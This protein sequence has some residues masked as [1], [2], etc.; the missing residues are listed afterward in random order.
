VIFVVVGRS[1]PWA[2]VLLQP[3]VAVPAMVNKQ[4]CQTVSSSVALPCAYTK[5]GADDVLNIV[6]STVSIPLT[7]SANVPTWGKKDNGE[8]SYVAQK[9]KLP[10]YFFFFFFSVR[11]CLEELFSKEYYSSKVIWAFLRATT[12]RC[13]FCVPLRLGANWPSDSVFDQGYNADRFLLLHMNPIETD[14]IGDQLQ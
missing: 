9:G 12:V 10:G 1:Q 8:F 14:R 5:I 4:E 11:S 6:S 3:A 7:V 2:D 13:H